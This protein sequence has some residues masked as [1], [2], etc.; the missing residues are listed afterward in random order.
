MQH[1]FDLSVRCYAVVNSLLN[2]EEVL[3]IV[4]FFYVIDSSV[5]GCIHMVL[6]VKSGARHENICCYNLMIQTSEEIYR[7]VSYREDLRDQLL[8]VEKSRCS[9][10]LF[11]I[12]GKMNFCDSSKTD[13]KINNKT[14]L[15]KQ[16]EVPFEF[17]KVLE[18]VCPVLTVETVSKEK[19]HSDHVS[20]HCYINIEYVTN[21]TIGTNYTE[22]SN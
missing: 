15:E 16:D 22:I 9:A 2:Y 1:F 3:L 19:K 20:L 10:K 6:P 7:S 21:G 17:R 8:K 12:K 5:V 14:E 13:I 4:I 18:V 11:N